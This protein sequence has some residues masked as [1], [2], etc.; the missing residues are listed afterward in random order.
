MSAKIHFYLRTD[1]PS[2]DGS[3]QIFLFFTLNRDQ[4][5]KIS[6][7]KFIPLKKE[8]KKLPLEQLYSLHPNKE[9]L[10][11]WDQ[12]KERAIKGA[13]NSESLNNYLDSE[14]ARANQILLRYELMNKPISV[15]LFKQAFLKVTGTNKFKEYFTQE[16]DEKRRHLIAND[17]YRGYKAVISKVNTFK[18]NLSLSDID[19][20]FLTRFENHMLK[21]ISEGGLGNIQSTVSKT[22]KMLRALVLIAIKNEDFPREAYPFKDYRIKHVDPILTTRDYLEPDDLMKVEQLLSPE[23]ISELTEG[24]VK[25]TKRFLF[26][27]Y[28]GLRYSDINSLNRQQHIFGKFVLNP[29][30]NEMVYRYYIEL[31]MSK[32]AQPVFIPLIDKAIELL[33]E[34]TGEYVFEKISNQKLNKHL[35]SINTKAGLNKKLSFHVARHSFATICFLYEIPEKVGQK[36]LGHKNRK[37]TEVYTHLSQNRIF[38]EMDKLNRGLSQFQVMVDEADTQKTDIKEMLPIIQNLSPEK[39]DQLKG[40]IKLLGS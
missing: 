36:L 25:A 32:T 33:Q 8:Y 35:K 11:C 31:N 39:L 40:L 30:T 26:A 1:R 10:Y 23:K 9:D 37:F 17:T 7:G 15:D 20:K 19:F 14:K 6:T 4:R 3:V 38:Y 22:M 28:T 5:I 34:S 18:P 29:K 2:K 24:E 27:C 16:L 12:K 21:P 13:E